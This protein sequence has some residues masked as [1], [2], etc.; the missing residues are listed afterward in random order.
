VHFFWNYKEHVSSLINQPDVNFGINIMEFNKLYGSQARDKLLME[1]SSK[2]SLDFYKHCFVSLGKQNYL[3][4][5][6]YF[7]ASRLKLLSRTE[8]GIQTAQAW[9]KDG[10][11]T[12]FQSDSPKFMRLKSLCSPSRQIRQFSCLS[13]FSL[14]KLFYLRTMLSS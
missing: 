1:V 14:R 7:H 13:A 10:L 4:N 6:N 12:E 9:V 2:S 3:N 11:I 5:H 8:R